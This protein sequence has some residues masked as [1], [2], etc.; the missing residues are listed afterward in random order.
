MALDGFDPKQKQKAADT[1]QPTTE[2]DI[3]AAQGILPTAGAYASKYLTEPLG[4]I[5][6]RFGAP[7]AAGMLAPIIAPEAIGG[8]ATGAIAT[9]LTDLPTEIGE[10]V[11]RQKERGQQVDLASATATGLAQAT[12]AGFG[13]PGTGALN[14]LL[15]P[16][17][18][19]EAELLAPKVLK[20]QITKEEAIAGLTGKVE[21]YAQ[22]VGVNAATGTGL[23][24]GTEEL[25]RAQAGQELMTPGE[26]GETA[27]TAGIL[28]PVFGALHPVGRGAAEAKI[29]EAANKRQTKLD[30]IAAKNQARE[31]A[32][33][34]I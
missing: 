13:I 14:K 10:N 8:L 33:F 22:S 16:Q 6:G 20:G 4:G 27:L 25:R 5:A 32:F 1:F 26:I 9:A 34:R 7:I 3:A 21:S 15:G 28:A 19:K 17:L 11:E 24:V 30:T 29:G 18:L 31:E 12:L 2:A 23:M